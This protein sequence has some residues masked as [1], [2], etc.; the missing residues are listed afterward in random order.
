MYKKN[1]W[2]LL[3]FH[4]VWESG[5]FY[6]KK[7]WKW[8]EINYMFIK[9]ILFFFHTIQNKKTFTKIHYFWNLKTSN[10]LFLTCKVFLVWWLSKSKGWFY[11]FLL[12]KK[13]K[14]KVVYCYILARN[15]QVPTMHLVWMCGE[16]KKK[17]MIWE[18]VN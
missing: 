9:I 11:C 1:I 14:L 18:R 3:I 15:F 17:C 16:V 6:K 13:N 12:C 2:F 4:W 5:I 10:L 7:T 8:K